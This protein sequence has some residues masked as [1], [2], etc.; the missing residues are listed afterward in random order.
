MAEVFSIL[1]TSMSCGNAHYSYQ[2]YQPGKI[3]LH[4]SVVMIEYLVATPWIIKATE[5]LQYEGCFGFHRAPNAKESRLC[6]RAW[7]S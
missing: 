3:T 7:F 2:H 1:T 4:F 5:Y 6:E